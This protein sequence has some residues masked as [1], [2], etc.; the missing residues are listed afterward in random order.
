VN[1]ATA[2]IQ[3]AQTSGQL[4][5]FD[6]ARF[7]FRLASFTITF[8]ASPTMRRYILGPHYSAE[9]EREAFLRSIREEIT[10][11]TAR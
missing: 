1:L 7:L 8:H 11:N 3:A 2:Y 5:D 4:G 6:V 10:G 9:E